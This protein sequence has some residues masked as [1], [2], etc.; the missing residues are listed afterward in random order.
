M[1]DL[2]TKATEMHFQAMLLPPRVFLGGFQTRSHTP[3][4]GSRSQEGHRTER[5]YAAHF[6]TSGRELPPLHASE[7]SLQRWISRGPDG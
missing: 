2:N 5:L 6:P 3:F 4:P 7:R 1:A